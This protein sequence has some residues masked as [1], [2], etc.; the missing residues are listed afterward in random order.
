MGLILSALAAAGDAGV[1]SMNQ[2][3]EQQNKLEALRTQSALQLQ[4]E[5]QL[6]QA[7][8]DI[9]ESARKQRVADINTGM[10]PLLEQGIINR[11]SAAR[12]D[13]LDGGTPEADGRTHKFTGSAAAWMAQAQA[14]PDSSPDKA[15][16]IK[17]I[18]QQFA[19]QKSKVV[20]SIKSMSDL[21]DEEK[22]KF[23]PTADQKRE[24]F[25][26][27]A[28]DQG[29]IEPDKV[30]S[31]HTKEGTLAAQMALGQAKLDAQTSIQQARLEAYNAKTQAQYD[32]AM[33]RV[34]AATA[35]AGG[36]KEVLGYIDG[37][38]KELD[39]DADNIRRTMDSELKAEPSPKKKALIQEKYAP[40]LKRIS[41]K[42]ASLDAD[43][44]FLREGLGLPRN[45]SAAA[46][47]SQ[48]TQP[49]SMLEA[50][51][52]GAVQVGTSGGKPVYQTPDGKKYIGK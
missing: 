26:Q 47:P 20:G 21:T 23:A 51:P 45:K 25:L 41:E 19:D 7:K 48:G 16:I 3:I 29:Y 13:N 35:R 32:A 39:S 2:E 10:Q 11:A 1:Q 52:P 5:Q 30:L 9:A 36:S 37:R 43:Y 12:A 6:L 31:A 4:N 28:M 24:A 22:T 14:M 15:A 33:A 40:D 46:E 8:N 44:D 42:R 27:S 38:R 18:Q 17:Q 34:E 50:L 49:K